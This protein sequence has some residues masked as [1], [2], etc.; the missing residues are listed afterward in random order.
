MDK[1]NGYYDEQSIVDPAAMNLASEHEPKS[2]IDITDQVAQ[3]EENSGETVLY[4]NNEKI[5]KFKHHGHKYEYEM[6]EGFEIDNNKIYKN[7]G[8]K[9]KAKQPEQPKSYVEGC[10]MGWC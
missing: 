5:G 6:A 1:T 7:L 10:D 9:G 2:H 8:Q 3:K 4:H